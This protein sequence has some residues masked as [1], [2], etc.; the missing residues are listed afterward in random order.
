MRH[1]AVC[2]HLSS[3]LHPSERS[4][5]SARC[6]SRAREKIKSLHRLS[7]TLQSSHKFSALLLFISVAAQRPSLFVSRMVS[8]EKF[9]ARIFEFGGGHCLLF[10]RSHVAWRPPETALFFIPLHQIAKS[11]MQQSVTAHVLSG[12]LSGYTFCIYKHHSRYYPKGEGGGEGSGNSFRG[13]MIQNL[14]CM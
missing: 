5:L 3:P 8:T 7:L 4:G 2:H 12:F 11:I 14:P 9:T 1:G 6:L 10:F 13:L